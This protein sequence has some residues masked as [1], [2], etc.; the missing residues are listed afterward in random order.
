M[1]PLLHTA[2]SERFRGAVHDEALYKSTFTLL[3]FTYTSE[4]LPCAYI[5]Y[6]A[7]VNTEFDFVI[8]VIFTISSSRHRTYYCNQLFMQKGLVIHQRKQRKIDLGQVNG[9]LKFVL[10]SS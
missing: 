10:S 7:L 6:N 3:Y 4:V 2:I 5:P 1:I 9:C 8:F